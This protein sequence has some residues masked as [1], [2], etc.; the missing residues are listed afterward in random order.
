M[1]RTLINFLS[2]VIIAIL[3]ASVLLPILSIVAGIS[4]GFSADDQ[5][6]QVAPDPYSNPVVISMNADEQTLLSP[7]DTIY[8]EKSGEAYP[9][10]V[11][12]AIIMLPED[13]APGWTE[14]AVMIG[15]CLTTICFI[16]L[17]IDFV[18]FIVKINR[19]QVFVP[20]NVRYLRR[21]SLW[22]I[23]ISI[24][25]VVSGVMDEITVDNLNLELYGYTL[26]ASWELPWTTLM[27]GFLSLLMAQIWRRGIE[28]KEDQEYTI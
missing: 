14:T 18:K 10:T 16:L 12:Q 24:F 5:P 25:S 1:N 27:L 11:K 15:Y 19:G 6:Q 28:L 3:A 2:V 21:I 8:F 22:L 17:M 4:D 13:K 20:I 26:S 9:L 7:R 23:L